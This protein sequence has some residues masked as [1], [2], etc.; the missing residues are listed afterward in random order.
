MAKLNLRDANLRKEAGLR[1]NTVSTPSQLP[2][3]NKKQHKRGSWETER[4]ILDAV[5][6]TNG[7]TRLQI[8]RAI[9]RKKTPHLISIVEN[10]VEHGLLLRDATPRR[11][12]MLQYTYYPTE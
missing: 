7:M 10:L 1:V 3:P 6:E 12:G 11:N 8:A 2:A 9:G 5:S 4:M